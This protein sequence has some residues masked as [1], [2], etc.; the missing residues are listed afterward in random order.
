MSINYSG[1]G[2]LKQLGVEQK[3]LN[4]VENAKLTISHSGS[5]FMFLL[6]SGQPV[7]QVP[8][9]GQA[10]TLLQKGI[11][12]AASKESIK[13]LVQMALGKAAKNFSDENVLYENPASKIASLVPG[14]LQIQGAQDGLMMSPYESAAA[15]K[16]L[17]E[18]DVVTTADGSHTSTSLKEPSTGTHVKLCDAKKVLQHVLGTSAGSVYVCT[19]I[20]AALNVKIAARL[21][22]SQLSIRV[23]G[24]VTDVSVQSKLS[25]FGLSID[26][27]KKYASVH[28]EVPSWEAA[29][30]TLGALYAVLGIRKALEIASMSK[31]KKELGAW[32]V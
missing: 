28:V 1:T 7:A 8:V 5:K 23:E 9:T 12:A 13:Y 30:K 24:N 2:I 14:P 17:L 32:S 4:L 3:Y 11:L 16:K 25:D 27:S 22:G 31:L 10:I 21:K 18:T 29:V 15:I 19:A 20:F 26:S 6:P